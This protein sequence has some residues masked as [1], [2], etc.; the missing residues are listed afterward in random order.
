MRRLSTLVAGVLLVA[1]PVLQGISTFFWNGSSQGIDTGAILVPATVCWIVGLTAVFRTIEDRAP[2]YAAIAYPFAMYGC[3]GGATFGVQG[4]QE[5]LFHF[6]HAEALRLLD[7]HMFAAELAFWIAGPLFPLSLAVLGAM[8]IRIRAVPVAVGVLV[9]A[10]ALA[11]P[12]SRVPRVPLIA[13]LADLLLLLPFAY[14][15]IRMATQRLG[16]RADA[17]RPTQR[18]G[19]PDTGLPTVRS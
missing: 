7:Q 8:L 6:D 19:E 14:L 9:C 4:M 18:D 1:A 15:G 10:G 16:H 2:R 5:E 12:L 13:H 11:F 17:G 3:V